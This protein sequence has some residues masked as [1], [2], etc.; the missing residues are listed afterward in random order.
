MLQL[1]PA[2]NA[3][4]STVITLTEPVRNDEGTWDARLDHK[5]SSKDSI[6]GRF[7]YD[8]AT[9]FVPGGSPGAEA[10]AFGSTQ[11]INNHGRNVALSETHVFS[12]TT[13]NQVSIGLSIAFS[14]TSFRLARAL[15]RLPIIGIPGADLGSKCDSI[16]GYPA[17]R[18][19]PTK[20][21]I[22]CGM[23]F[24]R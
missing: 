6:F 14:T 17:S 15:A 4:A 23:T 2:P 1:Y 11:F 13:I 19:S 5:F 9:T 18:T 21:C 7:S 20:D 22:S 12:A 10:N 24:I 16:T 8:Q 3:N